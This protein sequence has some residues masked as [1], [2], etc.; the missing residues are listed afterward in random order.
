MKKLLE[1]L[2]AV[3]PI[4]WLLLLAA[5]GGVILVLWMNHLKNTPEAP[6]GEWRPIRTAPQVAKV[7]KTPTPIKTGK[8]EVYEP[9]AKAKLKLPE[10]IFEDETKAVLEATRVDASEHAHTVTSLVDTDTGE[11]ETIVRKEPLPWIAWDTRG[12]AGVYA[13][14]KNGDPAIRL[15]AKQGIVQMKSLHIGVV[16]SLDQPLNSGQQPDTFIGIGAWARW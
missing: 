1:A 7:E 14:L 9:K 3:N 12:E 15:E 16:G 8:V 11:V 13:G 2:N 10:D 6:V 4:Y 5:T